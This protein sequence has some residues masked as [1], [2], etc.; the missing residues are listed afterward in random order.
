MKRFASLLAG[1][2]LSACLAGCTNRPSPS[3]EGPPE[4]LYAFRGYA[5]AYEEAIFC[6]RTVEAARLSRHML[7]FLIEKRALSRET[8]IVAGNWG[9]FARKADVG[10]EVAKCYTLRHE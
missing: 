7:P 9:Y 1:L 8:S 2:A 6:F 3:H 5:R 10:Y 4:S